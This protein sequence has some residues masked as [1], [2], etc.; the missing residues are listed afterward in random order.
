[1]IFVWGYTAVMIT[2]AVVGF[3]REYIWRR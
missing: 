2:I 1:M 3:I